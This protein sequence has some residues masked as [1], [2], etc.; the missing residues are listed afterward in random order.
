MKRL[1]FLTAFFVLGAPA[2]YAQ[3]PDLGTDAQREAGKVTYNQ[4]CAH[5]HGEN[6]DA[7]SIATAYL[8]PAPRDF[9]SGN[10]KFRTTASGELPTTEDIKRSIRDGMPYTSMPAWRGILSESNITNLA[11]Y[12][13]SFDQ[14]FAGPYGTPEVVTVPRAPAFDESLLARGQLRACAL[15]ATARPRHRCPTR[16]R[17]GNLQP[18]MR[19]LSWR[20]RRRPKHR[21]RLPPPGTARL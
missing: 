9:S 13:K 20:K 2:L 4:K 15:R 1:A 11:Y 21:H 17:Q 14:T 8:R 5:C 12:I 3:Q 7:Q 18:K 10:F 6:G 16:S 19:P